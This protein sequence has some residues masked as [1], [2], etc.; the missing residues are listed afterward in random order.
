MF[1]PLKACLL[2]G[3]TRNDICCQFGIVFSNTGITLYVGLSAVEYFRI[4]TL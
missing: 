1:A 4:T 2:Q 3:T